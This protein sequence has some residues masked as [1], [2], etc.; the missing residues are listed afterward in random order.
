MGL[1]RLVVAIDRQG[2]LIVEG[3]ARTGESAARWWADEAAR[4]REGRRILAAPGEELPTLVVIRADRDAAYGDVRKTLAQAQLPGFSHFTLVI[5]REEALAMSRRP[6]RPRPPEEVSFP[7][8][9]FLDMAFQLLAFFIL[10]FR[11]PS[12]E[13]RIDLYLPTAAATL[14]AV[15]RGRVLAPRADDPDLE[16][17]L[18]VRAEADER[19]AT[20]PTRAARAIRPLSD[21]RE[22]GDGSGNTQRLLNGQPLRVS[23]VAP[24]AL[25][26]EEAARIVGACEAAGVSAIRL[27]SPEGPQR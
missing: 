25:S 23:F 5:L 13:A 14:P 1:D 24:D 4:R 3:R 11:A 15:P 10:T 17:D 19:R 22:P 18:Q 16:T 12:R 6:K 8:T 7:V 27:V 20:W 26:Y 9:P 2:R 21:P